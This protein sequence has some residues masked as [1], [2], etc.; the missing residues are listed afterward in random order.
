MML[1]NFR[2]AVR[3]TRGAFSGKIAILISLVSAIIALASLITTLIINFWHTEDLI[4]Y[5]NFSET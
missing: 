2:A 1:T 5:V 4:I 3:K